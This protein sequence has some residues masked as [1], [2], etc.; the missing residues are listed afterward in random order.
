[1]DLERDIADFLGTEASILYSQAFATISSVIA[2]FAKRG[3]IIV[4][5]RG[6]NF[7]IQKAC[8]SAAPPSAGSITMILK[9]SRTSSRV[10]KRNVGNAADRSRDGLSSQ[11]VYSRETAP[12]L[13]YRNS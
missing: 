2:A 5:D 8:R 12:Y 13:I 9:A 6:V 7:A 1:M 4:A 3:D 11:K 10:L